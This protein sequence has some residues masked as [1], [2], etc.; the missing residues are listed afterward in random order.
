MYCLQWKNQGCDWKKK[1]KIH[2]TWKKRSLQPNSNG[3]LLTPL[4]SSSLFRKGYPFIFI[5]SFKHLPTLKSHT[6]S[7]Q[8][9]R[10]G[11]SS[12]SLSASQ[13]FSNLSSTS[14]PTTKSLKTISSLLDPTTFPSLATSYGSANP[15]LNSNTSSA[16]SISSTDPSS[17]FT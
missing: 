9:W 6:H 1:K 16:N 12:L 4:L 17:P 10:P 11:S 7:Y 5:S 8:T 3:Q 13:P 2:E 14:P 15:S